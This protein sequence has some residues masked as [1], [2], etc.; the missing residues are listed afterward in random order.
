MEYDLERLNV[1]IQHFE[2]HPKHRSQIE[3]Q[4]LQEILDNMDLRFDGTQAVNALAVCEEDC[5]VCYETAK[6][7]HTCQTCNNWV[8]QNCKQKL[9]TCPTCR[10]GF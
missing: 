2:K 6:E 10:E 9:R 5:H 1:E 8:C 3:L 7:C 4:I